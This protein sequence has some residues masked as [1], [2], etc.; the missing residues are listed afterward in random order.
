MTHHENRSGNIMTTRRLATAQLGAL[1]LLT[2]CASTEVTSRQAYQGDRLPR[3]GRI[4][5]YNFA[6][7]PADLPPGLP[8][9]A[10]ALGV[11]PAA[12]TNPPTPEELATVRQL[13]FLVA[14]ELA[15][16]LRAMGLPAVEGDAA[17]MPP[18]SLQ[19]DDIA[20][21]GY[22]AT[23]NQG[24]EAKR[25][26]IGFG[27]GAPEL[28]TVVE[29]FQMAPQGTLR[30]LGGGTVDAG[31]TKVPGMLV[32]LAVVAANGNPIGLVIN[33]AIRRTARCRARPRSKARR[34]APPTR[35][36]RR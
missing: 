3:P 2:A 26:M 28:N 11:A 4:V 7:T 8:S 23:V 10:A 32:P 21:A 12:A 13:G 5:V 25:L 16:N 9:E 1:L 20:L 15:K 30:R 36:R 34:S 31:G 14:Q 27:S 18:A 33:G 22:F 17:A 24:S 19:P 6:A 29:G 35:S